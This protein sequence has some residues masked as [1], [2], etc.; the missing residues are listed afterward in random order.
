MRL[1]A[2]DA[3][4]VHVRALAL[5]V[6]FAAGEEMRTEV[7]AKFTRE[8]VSQELEAAGMQLARW[9]TDPDGDF[10]LLLAR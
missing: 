7:S 10:A 6:A 9:W 8:R 4:T 5:E 3:H 1:R 2:V